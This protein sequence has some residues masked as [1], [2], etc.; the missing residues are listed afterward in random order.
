MSAVRDDVMR[1]IDA[2]VTHK[3]KCYIFVC[4]SCD[5]LATSTRSDALTCSTACRVRAHRNRSIK[6]LRE[7]ATMVGLVDDDNRPMPALIKQ[8]EA[9]KR[10][11]PD[12][13]QRLEDNTLSIR[14]A[15]SEVVPAFWDVVKLQIESESQSSSRARP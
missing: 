12:L 5:L 10:L 13:F 3:V 11:R 6:G 9:I 2:P 15:Q 7:L 1:E 14:Q 8:G 4:C